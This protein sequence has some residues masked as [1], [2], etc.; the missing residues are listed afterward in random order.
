MSL[1][2]PIKT[3]PSGIKKIQEQRVNFFLPMNFNKKIS[4]GIR[5]SNGIIHE[6]IFTLSYRVSWS[7]SGTESLVYQ[8]R[9]I[10]FQRYTSY[11]TSTTI[12]IIP[13]RKNARAISGSPA[14]AVT[15]E[16]GGNGK[17]VTSGEGTVVKVV[18]VI[19]EI[20]L[21]PLAIV[22]GERVALGQ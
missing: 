12:T 20:A 19:S 1:S 18:T 2:C 5:T 13:P 17:G 7:L 6:G 14:L 4:Y 3:G 11:I 22:S 15:P 8:S 9:L 10:F 21:E 16:P